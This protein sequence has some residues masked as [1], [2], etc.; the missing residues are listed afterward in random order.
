MSSL[1]ACT[2]HQISVQQSWWWWRRRI[3]KIPSYTCSN[4]S[5]TKQS[6]IFSNTLI[7]VH[8]NEW[9]QFWGPWTRQV[10]LIKWPVSPHR[11][12]R[13]NSPCNKEVQ[14]ESCAAAAE[15][16][17]RRLP[18]LWNEVLGTQHMLHQACPRNPI[19]IGWLCNIRFIPG[20]GAP[21]TGSWGGGGSDVQARRAC[22]VETRSTR[23]AS[24]AS[25]TKPWW[26]TVQGVAGARAEVCLR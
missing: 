15:P 1:M 3:G 20:A 16:T 14:I 19:Y 24:A 7:K 18:R 21:L 6:L 23:F 4:R 10:N 12:S 25:L 22:A 17:G 2:S 8:C 26:Q 11:N 9:R 13:A 5:A